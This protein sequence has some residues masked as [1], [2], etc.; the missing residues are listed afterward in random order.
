FNAQPLLPG[1]ITSDEPGIYREG[2]HGV[3]HEILL[4]CVEDGRNDFG[5]WLS[6]E[7]LTLCHIDTSAIVRSLML[8]EEIAWLNA[9]NSAVYDRLSPRLPAH[10][11]AWLRS[12]TLP[13]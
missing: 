1:M 8:P 4:L 9:Y 2:R 13:I 3:R 5:D 6:F 12:K 11:A 10:V 7:V